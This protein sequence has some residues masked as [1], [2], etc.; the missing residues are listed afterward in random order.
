MRQCNF[1]RQHYFPESPLK[2]SM[3]KIHLHG[4]TQTFQLSPSLRTKISKP[5]SRSFSRV[6]RLGLHVF[7]TTWCGCLWPMNNSFVSMDISSFHFPWFKGMIL[8][9]GNFNKGFLKQKVRLWECPSGV[10]QWRLGKP[11]TL[12]MWWSNILTYWSMLVISGRGGIFYRT[13]FD[14]TMVSFSFERCLFFKL[15]PSTFDFD[16]RDHWAIRKSPQ[17]QLMLTS[18][19]WPSL[20]SPWIETIKPYNH[21]I[22]FLGLKPRKGKL[23]RNSGETTN[24]C[25]T[26]VPTLLLWQCATD[27]SIKCQPPSNYWSI[28]KFWRAL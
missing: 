9:L 5:C 21:V 11:K 16:T 25:K 4:S 12:D 7:F 19:M 13:R 28:Q 23:P 8:D 1:H 26:F 14:P 24:P 15:N 18:T 2:A 27:P 6:C 20:K 22:Y 3:S 17:V 10:S